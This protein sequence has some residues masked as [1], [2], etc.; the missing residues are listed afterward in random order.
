MLLRIAAGVA[1]I[2]QGGCYFADSL[3]SSWPNSLFGGTLLLCGALLLIGLMT[4][5]V[6]APVG[7]APVSLAAAWVAPPG[8]NLFDSALPAILMGVIATS[9]VLLGPGSISVDARLFG[10]REIII[11]PAFRSGS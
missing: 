4:P 5:I 2:I 8:V 10:R 7:L 1:A 11:P 3:P 9:L 6:C